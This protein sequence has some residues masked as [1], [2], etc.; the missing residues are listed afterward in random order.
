MSVFTLEDIALGFGLILIGI[1]IG[2]W[3]RINSAI[4]DWQTRD[5]RTPEQRAE[6]QRRLMIQPEDD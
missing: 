1:V 2:A 4:Y 5:R 3:P 6:D